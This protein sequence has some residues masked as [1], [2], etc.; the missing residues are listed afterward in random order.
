MLIVLYERRVILH[1]YSTFVHTAVCGAVV[2]P[3]NGYC[4]E[5]SHLSLAHCFPFSLSSRL[6]FKPQLSNKFAYQI[7][8][9]IPVPPFR[10]TYSAHRK[11]TY[12]RIMYDISVR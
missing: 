7:S 9:C 4:I 5:L 11:D 2:R 3:T 8:V 6:S 12:I 1:V 10:I